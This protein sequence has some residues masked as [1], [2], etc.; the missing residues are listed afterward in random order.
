MC[1]QSN[2]SKPISV[3]RNGFGV[4]PTWPAGTS[5]EDLF[6]SALQKVDQKV[7][8]VRGIATFLYIIS[9][10]AHKASLKPQQNFVHLAKDFGSLQHLAAKVLYVGI[11]LFIGHVWLVNT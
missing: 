4:L 5:K 3:E 9:L 7:S 6:C 11:H 8:Q 2:L 1:G 10:I